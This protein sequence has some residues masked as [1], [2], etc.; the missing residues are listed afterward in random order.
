MESTQ[1]D[2]IEQMEGEIGA[3]SYENFEKF[4]AKHRAQEQ[5]QEEQIDHKNPDETSMQSKKTSNL[6]YATK[7]L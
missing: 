1:L 5:A 7:Y 3:L 4:V 6:Q 2:N